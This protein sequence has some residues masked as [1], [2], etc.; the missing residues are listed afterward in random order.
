MWFDFSWLKTV[1]IK[2]NNEIICCLNRTV[3]VWG[4]AVKKEIE[5]RGFMK[6]NANNFPVDRKDRKRNKKRKKK[7]R[8]HKKKSSKKLVFVS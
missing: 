5:G 1:I 4:Y 6:F 8:K 3:S 7:E 2:T